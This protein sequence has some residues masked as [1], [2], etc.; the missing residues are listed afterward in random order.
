MPLGLTLLFSIESQSSSGVPVFYGVAVEDFEAED[1]MQEI[2][3]DFLLSIFK[4]ELVS[5]V[6]LKR[7]VNCSYFEKDLQG[8]SKALQTLSLDKTI[9]SVDFLHS[10]RV[11]KS[12]TLS[13]LK[14]ALKELNKDEQLWFSWER[15]TSKLIEDCYDLTSLLEIEKIIQDFKLVKE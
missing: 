15:Q 8:L 6:R 14:D 2:E 10:N 11:W 1:W 4:S 3:I 9:K 7:K 5:R 12:L 13:Q